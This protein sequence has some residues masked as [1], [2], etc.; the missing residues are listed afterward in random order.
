MSLLDNFFNTK[1]PDYMKGLLGDNANLQ[2]TANTTGL[3]NMALGYLAAPKHSQLGLGRILAGSYMA[4]QQG[5]QGTYDN[6][7]Q[8]WQTGN[9]IDEFNKAKAKETAKDSY[10]QHWG[11]PNSTTQTDATPEQTN[12]V[13][14]AQPVD[15]PS[16]SLQPQVTP[17]QPATSTP[18]FDQNK[19]LMGAVRSGAIDFKD[20]LTLMSK[21]KPSAD[22]VY[23]GNIKMWEHQNP[24]ATALLPYNNV[25][26]SDQL[27]YTTPS[28]DTV[29]GSTHQSANNKATIAGEAA[30]EA[31]KNKN[32]FLSDQ[33]PTPTVQLTASLADIADT[34][35]ATGKTT[36]QVTADL[37]SKGYKIGK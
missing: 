14:V 20:Y 15:H 33:V 22:A 26:L 16:Y 10:I 29:Y 12:N 31:E 4:G 17:A 35:K 18:V 37:K 9:K 25:P 32:P 5:A 11:V 2:N 19:A 34:A 24:N 13:P 23:N 36:A 21:D 3:V 27:K 8:N 30:R 7:L 1:Q 6:A 28:A